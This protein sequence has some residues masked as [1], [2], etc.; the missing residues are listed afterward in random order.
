MRIME[1]E[2][3]AAIE[4]TKMVL[5]QERPCKACV[6]SNEACDWCMENKIPINRFMRGCRKFMTNEEAVRQVAIAEQ[7]R[8]R[9][10]MT[11]ILFEMDIMGYLANA[12]ALL[13]EKVDKRIEKNHEGVE[14][15]TREKE[16]Q[17]KSKGRRQK[18][19]KAYKDIKFKMKDVRSVFENYVEYYF[20]CMFA[21]KDGS[22]D[23]KESD[24][25]LAN[26]GVIAFI[27]S[28]IVD[29]ILDNG[30][31]ANK[32]LAFLDTLEGANILDEDDYGS[33]LIKR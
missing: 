30:D 26:S 24:K 17:M 12:A 23:I 15:T 25:N 2:T 22:Y 20:D 1:V 11:K 14:Q 3:E 10:E 21:E 29:K 18:L 32:I 19:L 28:K 27:N 5:E 33:F 9:T 13:L 16:K 8:Q 4:L 31:N 7:E 6:Y